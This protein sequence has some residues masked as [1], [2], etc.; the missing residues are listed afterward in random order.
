GEPENYDL[1]QEA[2]LRP[3]INVEPNEE[4]VY[5]ALKHL[6]LHPE[7]LPQLKKDSVEY[8]HRY[9]DHCKVAQQYLAFWKE[10]M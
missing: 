2:E 3:I 9:H 8:I 10:K 5:Q 1:L 4:S 6:I 7:C